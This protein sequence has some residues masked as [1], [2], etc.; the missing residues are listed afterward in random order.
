M[1]KPEKSERKSLAGMAGM[2]LMESC[3]TKAYHTFLKSSEPSSSADTTCGRQ[4]KRKQSRIFSEFLSHIG[5]KNG[6][7]DRIFAKFMI[8]EKV[9]V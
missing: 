8:F 6:R 9:I 7:F 4:G 3:I 1:D 2:T 5:Q